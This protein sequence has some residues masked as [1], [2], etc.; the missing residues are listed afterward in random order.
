MKINWYK[1][2]FQLAW[3]GHTRLKKEGLSLDFRWEVR[4]HYHNRRSKVKGYILFLNGG[5]ISTAK[6]ADTLL[7]RAATLATKMGHKKGKAGILW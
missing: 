2:P 7:E 3:R 1:F 4:A 6:R 5:G